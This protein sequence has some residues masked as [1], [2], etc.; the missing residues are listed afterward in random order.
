M[1]DRSG[2]AVVMS[3][4]AE[5]KQ[6]YQNLHGDHWKIAEY[7]VNRCGDFTFDSERVRFISAFLMASAQAGRAPEE[8]T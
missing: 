6:V 1:S 8:P 3:P 5:A 4:D 7:V 2:S